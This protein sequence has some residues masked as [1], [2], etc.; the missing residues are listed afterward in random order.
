[1]RRHYYSKRSKAAHRAFLKRMKA[2]PPWLRRGPARFYIF[3]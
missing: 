3:R 2:A 1:M